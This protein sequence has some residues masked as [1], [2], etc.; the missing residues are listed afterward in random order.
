MSSR[1][2]ANEL[3]QQATA[4]RVMLANGDV[5]LVDRDSVTAGEIV[6]DCARAVGI[7]PSTMR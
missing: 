7:G 1:T 6:T 3:G 5:H 2:N 4:I